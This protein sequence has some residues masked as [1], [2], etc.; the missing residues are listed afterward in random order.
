MAN[1]SLDAGAPLGTGCGCSARLNEG[2]FLANLAA[3]GHACR[4]G[5]MGGTF[6]PIHNGHLEIARRACESLGLSGVLFVVA[7]DPWM[8]HGRA[9]TPAEDRFAMVQA[10]IEGD[11]R[12]AASRMEIDRAGETYTVDTLRELRRFL[13]SNVELCFLMGADAAAR[14]GEWREVSALGSLARFAVVSQRDD[15]ALDKRGL[16]RLAQTIGAREILQVAMP[17]MD[18]SSTDLREKVRQGRSIRDEVPAVVA[19]YI[20]SHGLYQH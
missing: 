13:P 5:V 16:S 8:K 11:V 6:D 14:L 1:G 2:D 9:L 7:G 19:D 12:F 4:L 17:R 3:D 18:V 10:A 20:E 15:V